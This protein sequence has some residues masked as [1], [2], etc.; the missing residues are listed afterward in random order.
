MAASSLC[1]VAEGGWALS[2]AAGTR[3][4]DTGPA[5]CGMSGFVGFLKEAFS[6]PEL[7]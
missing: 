3:F 6:I 5:C 2:G 4:W 1:G 7:S